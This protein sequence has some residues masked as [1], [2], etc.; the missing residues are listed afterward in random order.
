MNSLPLVESFTS[1]GSKFF[2]H[3]EAMTKLRNGQGQPI[4]SHIML[5]DICNHK[6]AFCSVQK[7]AGDSLKFWDVL[8]Y[9]DILK[10]YGLKAVILS[11]GGNPILYKCKVTGND[12]NDMVSALHD[13]EVEIGLI[14]NGMPLKEYQNHRPTGI[15]FADPADEIIYSW[16]SVYPSTL[17]KLLWIRISM[18]GLDHPEREVYVPDIDPSKTTLGFSYVAHD[19][20]KE[21]ADPHHGAVS[22]P[23][24]LISRPKHSMPDEQF[25]ERIPR[26]ITQIRDLVIRHKPEYVRLLPNC[27]E[28]EL[29]HFRCEQLQYMAD[30]INSATNTQTVFVQYKPPSAPK[31]CYLG[32]IHPVLN[33]DGYVYPCDSCV[34]NEDA[35]H[36]FANPWRI[37]HW[38]EIQ[39]IYERPVQSLIE[40]PAKQCPGCVFPTSN[41]VLGSVVDGTANI[42]PPQVEPKHRNFV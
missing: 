34:L 29:I 3:Q 30:T 39:T 21:P 41:A 16:K 32:Y 9:V 6:C 10:R 23:L 5:T 31:A 37:C 19:V 14:T 1:T 24:D 26:L 33:C 2:A 17:D 35:E 25:E 15:P 28:P 12:F 18:S 20:Y 13:R 4:V 8:Q 11:G 36:Q 7:R 22:R 42:Q 38:S 40:D 27:L